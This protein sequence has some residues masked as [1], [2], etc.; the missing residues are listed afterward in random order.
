MAT[1][2]VIRSA[3]EINPPLLLPLWPYELSPVKP[4]TFAVLLAVAS[5]TDES[6]VDGLVLL[7]VLGLSAPIHTRKK[8]KLQSLL[9]CK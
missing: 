1:N 4:T 5:L 7:L 9:Q 3:K 2:E 6:V 8:S